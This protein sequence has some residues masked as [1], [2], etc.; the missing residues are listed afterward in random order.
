MNDF[1][2]QYGDVLTVEQ[3]QEIKRNTNA[4]LKK[5]Y[6]ELKPV[7]EEATKQIVRGL[8]DRIAQEIPEIAGV[9]LKYSEMK[10][11]RGF[12]SVLSIEPEIG[13]GF[14]YLRV[15][16]ALLWGGYRKCSKGK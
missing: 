14:L 8:K 15:W 12:W 9:N 6:G 3:A 2:K 11:L 5:S 1:R 7:T 4:F 16:L 10:T 13:T